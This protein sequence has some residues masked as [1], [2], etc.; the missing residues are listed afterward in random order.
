MESFRICRAKHR[1]SLKSGAGFTTKRENQKRN[2]YFS[3]V[4]ERRE[5]TR[6]SGFTLAELMVVLGIIV[7]L[8]YIVLTSQST[9]NKTLI[10]ANTAYDVALSLRSAETFG[11]GS[12]G[13]SGAST[14]T[15]YGIHFDRSTPGSYLIFADISPSSANGLNCHGLRPGANGSEP[16]A[17]PGDCMYTPPLDLKVSD[18]TIGNGIK[19]TDFCV[20][21]VSWACAST[22]LTSLDIV[23]ARPNADALMSTGGSTGVVTYNATISKAC[24]TLASPQGGARFI[25]VAKSG[26]I[27]ANAT[28]DPSSCHTLP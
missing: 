28:S 1:F 22:G 6:S 13:I 8:S 23:F 21:T 16:D 26:Q 5:Q 19:I 15:G 27:V 12:R 11:L 2:S 18:Y 4:N 17:Q 20:L 3:F 24:L 7:V 25:T 9:F 14:N 10:L